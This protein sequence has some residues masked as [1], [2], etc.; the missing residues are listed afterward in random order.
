MVVFYSAFSLLLCSS[1]TLGC[2]WRGI[3]WYQ[4]HPSAKR[5]LRTEFVALGY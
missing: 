2:L 1:S 5:V 4:I 3:S